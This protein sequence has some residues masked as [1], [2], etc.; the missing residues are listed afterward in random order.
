MLNEREF[1]FLTATGRRP[2]T[3]LRVWLII[4]TVATGVVL[5]WIGSVLALALVVTAVLALL[6]VWAWRL[7]TANRRPGGPAT[8]EG[9]YTVG[10]PSIIE[11][12][13][14]VPDR[15]PSGDA[16]ETWSGPK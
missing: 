6:P 13:D 8:I 11:F 15:D 16:R 4:A 7:C 2:P 14:E 5:L 9:D 10:T 1:A 3:W 12:Q